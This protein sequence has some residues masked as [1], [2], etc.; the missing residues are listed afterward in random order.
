[1]YNDYFGFRLAPFSVTPDSEVYYTNASYDEAFATVKHGVA[2]RKGLIVITGEVGTG[3][4]TLLHRFLRQLESEFDFAFV[5]NTQVTFDDLLRLALEDFGLSTAAEDR[6]SRIAALNRYLENRLKDNRA[7]CLV[8]DEAQNLSVEALGQ[9]RLLLNAETPKQKLLQIVLAGQPE[10]E[11]KLDQP[12]VRDLRQRVFSYARLR[13]L[14]LSEVEPYVVFRLEAAGYRGKPLFT[15]QAFE[16]LAFFAGGVPRLINIICDN[17][18]ISAYALSQHQISAE[19]IE[20]VASDLRLGALPQEEKS[21]QIDSASDGKQKIIPE[22][23]RF[24]G[25]S[26]VAFDVKHQPVP[27]Q[28]TFAPGG[29]WELSG[30]R[31]T[32]FKTAAFLTALLF[33]ATGAL[34]YSH[35]AR[36]YFSS[37]GSALEELVTQLADRDVERPAEE[38]AVRTPPGHKQP[39][40]PARPAEPYNPA[41]SSEMRQEQPAEV[42][43]VQTS[44]EA[45]AVEPRPKRAVPARLS[46]SRSPADTGV[47]SKNPNFAIQ[48]AIQNRGIAGVSVSFVDGTAYLEGAVATER[49]KEM[50]ERA[51]R[52]VPEV[53][54]VRNRIAVK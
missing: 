35:T 38:A 47:R 50:A 2:D 48:K 9:L 17:A 21:H 41:T 39:A 20:E 37:A 30:Q 23:T 34:I 22:E 15:A 6:V 42:P 28:G 36:K 51:A 11:K 53:R 29:H 1:M 3:K 33:A 5:F 27:A 18:L 7:V 43:E 13:P 16:R 44:P 25:F 45:P 40:E 14:K 24:P 19:I 54:A 52:S 12:S 10:L 31:P 32:G 49:Q 46:Q 8:V 26:P 4:T